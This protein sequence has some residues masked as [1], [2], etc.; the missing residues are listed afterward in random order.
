MIIPVGDFVSPADILQFQY[1]DNNLCRKK[2]YY[3]SN[4]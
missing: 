4:C 2:K 1:D 3:P